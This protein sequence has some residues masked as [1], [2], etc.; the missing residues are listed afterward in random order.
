MKSRISIIAALLSLSCLCDQ[1][2]HSTTPALEEAGS[3]EPVPSITLAVV[4]NANCICPTPILRVTGQNP[5]DFDLVLAH[6]PFEFN[7]SDMV[8]HRVRMGNESKPYEPSKYMPWL[9]EQALTQGISYFAPLLTWKL[10]AHSA[11]EFEVPMSV[12]ISAESLVPGYHEIN[13]SASFEY[14]HSEDS[15]RRGRRM[16]SSG[17]LCFTIGLNRLK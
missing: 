10:P 4:D 3:V 16:L 14:F 11:R 12:L 2:T 6:E 13:Y 9:E 1:Q 15:Q 7:E 5:T 8:W 17:V